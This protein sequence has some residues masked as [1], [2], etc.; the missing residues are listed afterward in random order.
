MFK[1]FSICSLWSLL[2]RNLP[3]NIFAIEIK[4][5]LCIVKIMV[6]LKIFS[7]IIWKY[8]DISEVGMVL[9]LWFLCGLRFLVVILCV[10]TKDRFIEN[11][12]Q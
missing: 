12:F 9:A 10:I 3:P 7:M 6:I 4:F 1:T 8:I 2:K 11:V 5:L